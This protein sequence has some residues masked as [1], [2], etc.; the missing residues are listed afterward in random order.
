MKKLHS[1]FVYL[2]IFGLLSCQSQTTESESIENDQQLYSRIL[3]EWQNLS[4]VVKI[5][6]RGNNPDSSAV[7]EVPEG[8]WEEVLQIRPIVTVYSN[9]ST[10]TS[11]YSNLKDSVVNISNGTWSV[12]GDSLYLLQSGQT[13]SYYTRFD[14]NKA[15]FT[16]YT[17]WDQDGNADDLYVGVQKKTQP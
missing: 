13:T 8:K 12:K 6:S 4:L 5:Q 3:G 1:I 14:G 10:F 17:D 7:F 2:M 9:D 11:T 15:E 16:G